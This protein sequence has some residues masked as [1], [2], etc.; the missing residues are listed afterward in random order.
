MKPELS[1]AVEDLKKEMSDATEI[2][3]IQAIIEITAA[4]CQ[5]CGSTAGYSCHCTDDE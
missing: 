2:E 5:Y 1:K 3:R 4:Y